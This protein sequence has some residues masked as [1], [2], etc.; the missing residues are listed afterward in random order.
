RI[1]LH[2]LYDAV[3]TEKLIEV[4]TDGIR[5]N[6]TPEEAAALEP[7]LNKTYRMF[8]TMHKG[9]V[10][11]LDYLPGEGTRV[12]INGERVGTVSGADFYRAVLRVWLGR[13][14]TDRRLKEA[15]LGVR[16]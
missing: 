2:F 6:H 13:T 4:W 16:S 3:S 11:Q 1:V 12:S 15:M 9:D 5:E 7:R 10:V 8:R 14:P